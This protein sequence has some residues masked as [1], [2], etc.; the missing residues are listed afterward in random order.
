MHESIMLSDR[1]SLHFICKHK[2]M[3]SRYWQK[4]LKNAN[5]MISK[6]YRGNSMWWRS[7]DLSN[8]HVWLILNGAYIKRT[9]MNYTW[10]YKHEVKPYFVKSQSITIL[11]LLLFQ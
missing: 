7:W 8:F 4:F 9:V 3:F 6:K 1:H 2:N 11:L 10:W 5:A